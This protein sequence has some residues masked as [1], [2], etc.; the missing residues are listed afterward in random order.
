MKEATK[1]PR[2]FTKLAAMLGMA[3][4]A[5][6]VIETP[7]PHSGDNSTDHAH[8]GLRKFQG[9]PIYS[10]RPGKLKGYMKNKSTF[11]KNR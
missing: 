7:P 9:N 1:R 4:V 8:G 11:N 5:E 2:A 3:Q 10:P 6:A